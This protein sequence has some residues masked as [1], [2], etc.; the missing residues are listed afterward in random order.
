MANFRDFFQ[1]GTEWILDL[2]SNLNISLSSKIQVFKNINSRKI[3]HFVHQRDKTSFGSVYTY[4]DEDLCLFKNFP[5]N[6]LVLPIIVPDE[7]LECSCSL[8]WLQ[9]YTQFYIS[10]V[11]MIKDYSSVD[12]Y[13]QYESLG[14]YS[15]QFCDSN[16]VCHFTK[17][18]N[19]CSIKS[20]KSKINNFWT[21][22]EAYIFIKWLEYV[23]LVILQPLFCGIGIINNILVIIVINNKSKK[24]LFKDVMYKHIFLNSLFNIGLSIF[25]LLSLINTCVF[26]ESNRFCSTVSRTESAQYFKIIGGEFMVNLLRTCSNLSFIF[27]SLSR[28]ILVANLK[29][30]ILV[31]KKFE[32]LN[33]F[34]YSAIL[35]FFGI[36]TSLF[37]FF[38]YGINEVYI[39]KIGFPYEIHNENLCYAFRE[40]CHF[41]ILSKFLTTCLMMYFYLS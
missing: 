31:F 28:L 29:E 38:D 30:R 5:H 40:N 25:M 20:I 3:I 26:Y 41:F 33:L 34:I 2:N 23:L 21:D 32:T 12:I 39:S 19:K 1:S 17:M 10:D 27:F 22:E 6:Q 7:R 14:M 11:K 24:M 16:K 13:Q 4:P 37:K 15:F 8:L 35:I 36:L 9:K 18:F